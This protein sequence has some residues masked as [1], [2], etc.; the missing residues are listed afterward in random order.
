MFF[1]TSQLGHQDAVI[2]INEDGK[3]QHGEI[4]NWKH[5]GNPIIALRVIPYFNVDK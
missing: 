1:Q 2:G 5:D 4:L 3:K